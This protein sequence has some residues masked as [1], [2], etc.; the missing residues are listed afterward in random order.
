MSIILENEIVPFTELHTKNIKQM[1]FKDIISLI[2]YACE[3]ISGS[4]DPWN[5]YYQEFQNDLILQNKLKC[6]KFRPITNDFSKRVEIFCDKGFIVSNNF[7]TILLRM[8][9]VENRKKGITGTYHYHKVL[10]HIIIPRT[11]VENIKKLSVYDLF[12]LL[13]PYVSYYM[14]IYN[15]ES[16]FEYQMANVIL[17]QLNQ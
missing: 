1:S 4:C 13:K 17:N 6:P 9:Y 12:E 3:K 14:K 11:S 15:D 2:F 8:L 7:L 5:N 16:M 10:D